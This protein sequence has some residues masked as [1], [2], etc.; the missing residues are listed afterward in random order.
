MV[1]KGLVVVGYDGSQGGEAAL[2]V[3]AREARLRQASLLIVAAWQA[4]PHYYGSRAA[5]SAQLRL[6]T[7][8]QKEMGRR[9]D[10]AAAQLREKATDLE[11]EARLLEGP[12]A[13]ILTREAKGAELLVVG[14][15]G[16]GG[17]R[18]LLLGSVSHQCAQ[19]AP[20]PVLIVPAQSAPASP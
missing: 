3:A 11:I 19:H 5:P 18:E 1:S 8:V 15:R 2:Q 7:D 6:A 13:Q 12:A 10:D 17:L 14:S 20:C 9:L 16:L 4:R